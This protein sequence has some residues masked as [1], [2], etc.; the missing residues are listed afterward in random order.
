VFFVSH[1]AISLLGEVNWIVT[2]LITRG[3][4]KIVRLK[5]AD[6]KP[7]RCIALHQNESYPSP[8][9]RSGP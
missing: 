9:G 6:L 3:G 8:D 7:D 2:R 5:S 4:A 1:A